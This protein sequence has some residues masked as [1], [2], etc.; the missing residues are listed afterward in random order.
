MAHFAARGEADVEEGVYCVIRNHVLAKWRA[1]VRRALT[2]EQ[3]RHGGAHRGVPMGGGV[4]GGCPRIR[5]S[6]SLFLSVSVRPTLCAA[7][8]AAP[9]RAVLSLRF[10][11]LPT[12]PNPRISRGVARPWRRPEGKSW[13]ATAASCVWPSGFSP[14]T[15]TS[16]S[17]WHA[18]RYPPYP[19]N[20]PTYPT[21][22][23]FLRV[24]APVSQSSKPSPLQLALPTKATVVVVGAGL[25]GLACARQLLARDRREKKILPLPP[26]P[27]PCRG[28]LLCPRFPGAAAA[29]PPACLRDLSPLSVARRGACLPLP[30]AP[31]PPLLCPLP[32]PP[33]RSSLSHPS[34]PSPPLPRFCPAGCGPP[35]C[36]ARSAHAPGRARVLRAAGGA[37]CLALC[38]VL[39]IALCCAV[40]RCCAVR[41]PLAAFGPRRVRGSGERFPTSRKSRGTETATARAHAPHHHSPY[42]YPYPQPQPSAVRCPLSA[43]GR[44]R[45][46]G[47]DGGLGDH[48]HPRQPAGS[49]GA[50]PTHPRL[51]CRRGLVLELCFLLS[52]AA[53]T[54]ARSILTHLPP[55]PFPPPPPPQSSL[56]HHSLIEKTSGEA[57]IRPLARHRVRVSALQAGRHPRCKTLGRSGG[58]PTPYPTP[59][60]RLPTLLTWFC[61]SRSAGRGAV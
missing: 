28:F 39:C 24:S 52:T 23:H 32:T 51:L 4:R 15:A 22:P 54:F 3:A 34:T 6:V 25:A 13:S 43:G 56:N 31:A 41:Q 29:S 37:L 2:E 14:S 57:A 27:L 48:W 5:L 42:P 46:R 60:P 17:G 19:P 36:C 26:L 50:L 44:T 9:C 38:I 16:T 11:L 21:R 53:S 20:P 1:D 30:L 59:Y 35:R 7:A 8:P 61:P 12:A 18:P 55:Q 47:G 45:G 49:G 40:L 33:A 58:I 10:P